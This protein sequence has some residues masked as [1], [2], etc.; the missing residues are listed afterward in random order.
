MNKMDLFEIMVITSLTFVV[1][2]SIIYFKR[3]SKNLELKYSSLFEYCE[4]LKDNINRL[5]EK[6]SSIKTK[7]I[8]ENIDELLKKEF[9]ENNGDVL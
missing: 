6:I 7:E 2:I 8:P 3:K 4:T 1:F 9:E 5:S